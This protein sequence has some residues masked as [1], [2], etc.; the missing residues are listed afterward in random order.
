MRGCQKFQENVLKNEEGKGV[1]R[2]D[3]MCHWK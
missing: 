1:E 3:I 2:G